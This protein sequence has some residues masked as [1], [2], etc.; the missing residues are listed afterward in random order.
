[1]WES[2]FCA[3]ANILLLFNLD[4]HERSFLC[5]G[6]RSIRTSYHRA[7]CRKLRYDF[8]DA[9]Q[10]LN[11]ACLFS[12][13]VNLIWWHM[14]SNLGSV[15]TPLSLFFNSWNVLFSFLR[16]WSVSL[17]GRVWITGG[18]HQAR[19]RNYKYIG[20][21]SSIIHS[22]NVRVISIFQL[23]HLCAFPYHFLHP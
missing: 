11:L 5:F 7:F 16:V 17:H 10:K 22:S 14:R 13:V 3:Q 15:H 12:L 8:K 1:M 6:L 20:F 2:I 4:I 9:T 21:V 23:N 18:D 19:R